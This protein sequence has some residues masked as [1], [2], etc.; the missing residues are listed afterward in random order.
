MVPI[1]LT[2]KERKTLCG[3]VSEGKAGYQK[4][5]RARV[6]LLADA[7]PEGPAQRDR[8]ISEAVGMCVSGIWQI[9]Q[10]FARVGLHGALERKKWR[11][12]P[13]FRPL[14]DVLRPHVI[15][16]RRSD[17]PEG[18]KRWTLRLLAEKL[19][20]LKIVPR[21]SHESVRIALR[22][23]KKSTTDRKKKSRHS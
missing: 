15:A 13:S 23:R 1:K 5:I 16:L 6:L 19:V 12:S 14:A 21:V 8:Q 17:P 20:E 2:T 9:R 7:S 22:S 10:R 11:H 18:A 4:T 3:L